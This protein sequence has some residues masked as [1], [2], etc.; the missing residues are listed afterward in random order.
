M[1]LIFFLAITGD[2]ISLGD[3]MNVGI[4]FTLLSVIYNLILNIIYLPKERIKSIENT[5]YT[6]LILTTLFGSIEGIFC[7]LVYPLFSAVVSKG[8]LVF[9]LFIKKSM[10]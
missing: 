7:Y 8:Y 6:V 4:S 1:I 9:L 10:L 5:I 2:T 3:S